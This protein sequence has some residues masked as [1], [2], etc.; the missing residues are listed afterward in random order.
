MFGALRG[1][2]SEA[3]CHRVQDGRAGGRVCLQ[4][5]VGIRSVAELTVSR[6][7]H[8]SVYLSNWVFQEIKEAAAR[9]GCGG[10]R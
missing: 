6:G 2:G 4:M 5:P 1:F 8:L 7:R 3:G 9:I 10:L